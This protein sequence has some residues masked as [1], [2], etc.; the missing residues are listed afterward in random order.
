MQGHVHLVIYM[1]RVKTW[2]KGLPFFTV[3]IETVFL[4]DELTEYI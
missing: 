1:R 3:K 4:L 2:K